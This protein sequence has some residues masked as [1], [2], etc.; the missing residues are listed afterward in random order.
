MPVWDS[1][2]S[3]FSPTIWLKM[4]QALIDS[5]TNYGSIQSW[6]IPP[7]M[8]YYG[9]APTVNSSGGATGA[10]T[11]LPTGGGNSFQMQPTT[12]YISE[13]TNKTFT[14][15]VWFKRNAAPSGNAEF[16]VS[17]WGAGNAY[18]GFIIPGTNDQY[19]SGKLIWNFN[20]ATTGTGNATYNTV[21]DNNWHF[22]AMTVNGGT[23]KYYI[24]GVPNGTQTG[25]SL[26]TTNIQT[27]HVGSSGNYGS[28]FHGGIDD[29][30]L[31]PSVLS[32]AN[33]AALYTATLDVM[34][35]RYWNGSAWVAPTDIKRY[36]NN[37]WNSVT[38]EI[39]G[40]NGSA[41]KVISK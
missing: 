12:G 5:G 41:F 16:I 11:T 37:N 19:N 7:T 35:L 23:V 28:P 21:C 27:F 4:D 10:W 24:D 38:T 18:I 13:I 2:L 39:K 25:L 6:T 14:T 22:A 40:W 29:F 32:D 1:T 8:N 30:F 9:N 26:G 34:K 36:Y 17:T 31:I 3:P 33:I 15:G 20:G